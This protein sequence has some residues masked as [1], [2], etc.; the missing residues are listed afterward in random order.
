MPV[1]LLAISG[2]LRE[3]STNTCL[4]R[5]L[6]EVI[7]CNQPRDR[8]EFDLFENSEDLPQFNPDKEA[9]AVLTVED[10]I[11]RSKR[12]DAFIVSSP[13]YAH[14]IPGSLKNALD[15]LV[16]TDAFIEKPFALYH[17]CPRSLHVPKALLEVLKTMSG[18]HVAD[19]D[20]TIDLK[21][22][23]E[24]GQ[25]ILLKQSSQEKIQNSI[26]ILVAYVNLR[27]NNLNT[28]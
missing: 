8:I 7:R 5:K 4:L 21:R 25:K 28:G 6:G 20:C 23:F 17:A 15:W 12:A 10:W 14:G 2:S 16:S 3:R 9:D 1:T 11:Q 24:K 13:E 18:K 26:S 22:N 27:L 19:S